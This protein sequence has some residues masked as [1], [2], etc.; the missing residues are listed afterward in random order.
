MPTADN[1]NGLACAQQVSV[2]SQQTM[3]A[4]VWAVQDQAFQA[5]GTCGPLMEAALAAS[6]E[7]PTEH[8][9]IVLEGL[10]GFTSKAGMLLLHAQGTVGPV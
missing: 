9:T 6:V 2:P 10:A 8:A 4:W 1:L 7:L 3:T 5:P